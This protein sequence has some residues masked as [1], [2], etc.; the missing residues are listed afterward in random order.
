MPW[1]IFFR[2]RFPFMMYRRTAALFLSSAASFGVIFVVEC[3][4]LLYSFTTSCMK[5]VQGRLNT[6]TRGSSMLFRAPRTRSAVF[7]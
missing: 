4:V 7:A 2:N 6:C 3:T 5:E 1:R